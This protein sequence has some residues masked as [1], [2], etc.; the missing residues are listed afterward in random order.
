MNYGVVVAGSEGYVGL[1]L[2]KLIEQHP[3]LNLLGVLKGT[4]EI[5]LI[6][7]NIFSLDEILERQSDIHLVFLATPPEISMEIA[8]KLSDSQ[9]IVIYLSGAFRI[10]KEQFKNWYHF[11]HLAP[12]L[13]EKSVYG[14]SPFISAKDHQLI[15]VP[16]CY[17]SAILLTILPL[18]I[19][20]LVIPDTLIIDAKSGISGAGKTPS[21][22]NTFCEIANNFFPYKIGH[23]QHTPEISNV[24][25]KFAN[26][27]FHFN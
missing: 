3:K 2:I 6:K 12:Q 19:A 1:E 8:L 13:L 14:L 16:G 18:L 26:K 11:E 27:P 7:E 17:A 25:S 4:K 21:L 23:H 20:D 5:S 22:R 9:I 15:A 24:F 10:E